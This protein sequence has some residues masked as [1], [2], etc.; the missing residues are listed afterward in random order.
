MADI[1]DKP[2]SEESIGELS[3]I[4]V[5]AAKKAKNAPPAERMILIQTEAAKRLIQ[6]LRE[7]GMGE[8]DDLISDSI[9]GETTLLESIDKALAEIDECEV[10][11]VGLKAKETA[12]EARRK[13]IEN[14]A[15]RI[16]AMIEQAMIA[17]EQPSMK[18]PSATI[19]LTKRQ[20]GLVVVNEADIPARF[21]AEQERPAPKLDRKALA[22]ALRNAEI[23]PGAMLD[24]GSLSLS[25]RRK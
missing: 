4:A 8:D 3:L 14:R 17:T 16:R 13:Q 10:L 25:V 21:W 9:E 20:A 12:F 15:D 2:G 23:I 1:V 24:N 7:L 19:S 11:I 5:N 18:L 22:D 6:N